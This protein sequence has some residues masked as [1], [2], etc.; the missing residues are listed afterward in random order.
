VP[1]K[2]LYAGTPEFAVPAL[3]A[4]VAAGHQVVAVYTQPDRPA[5]RGRVL[6]ASAVKARALAHGLVVHQP[7]TLR[8]AA[9]LHEFALSAPDVAVVA[10]YGLLLPP[11]ILRVP[12]LGCLNIHASLLPRW[13]GA[14]PVQRAILSGDSHTGISIMQ[15]DEGLDTGAVLSH[16]SIPIGGR[17]T[18]AELTERLAVLGAQALLSVLGELTAGHALSQPQSTEGVTYARKLDKKEA[19]INWRLS[20]REI[21]RQ[22]RAFVP[23]PICETRWRGAQLRIHA[24]EPVAGESLGVPG[25][26]V[27]AGPNGVEVATADGRLCLKRVQLA[28]RTVVSAHEFASAELKRGSLIGEQLTGFAL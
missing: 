20:A 23:W 19:Q 10:A 27:A 22:V 26:I 28:G 1:L 4:L 2:I 5:G 15:M 8:E 14:A 12:R 9:A 3:D 16:R 25:E 11:E 6:T 13:R 18:S 21:D 24:A 7:P 17:E